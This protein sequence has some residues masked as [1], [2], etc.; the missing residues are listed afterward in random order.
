MIGSRV[1]TS[2]LGDDLR[3]GESS[4]G[5]HCDPV[6]I[7]I[8]N[9][10]LVIPTRGGAVRANRLVGREQGG[11]SGQRMSN[12]QAIERISGPAENPRVPCDVSHV[13]GRRVDAVI[14]AKNGE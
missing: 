9:Y 6:E 12:D 10:R 2:E 11:P 3:L 13:A 14:L 7:E 8:A 1:A 5:R 4:L